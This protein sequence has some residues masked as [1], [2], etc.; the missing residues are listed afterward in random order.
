MPSGGVEPPYSSETRR[1]VSPWEE[2]DHRAT[3]AG[4]RIDADGYVRQVMFE[5][6]LKGESIRQM[7]S[8]GGTNKMVSKQFDAI[9][10]RKES[11]LRFTFSIPAREGDH[12]GPQQL[13]M[14]AVW[15]IKVR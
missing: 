4:I 8:I 1:F 3:T 5:D 6:C 11:N 9:G 7:P 15:V 12:R 13:K 14:A 10:T 2:D